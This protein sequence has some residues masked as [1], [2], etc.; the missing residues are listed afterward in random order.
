MSQ[1]SAEELEQLSNL[2]LSNDDQNTHL[3]FEIMEGKTWSATLLTELFVVCKLSGNDAFKQRAKAELERLDPNMSKVLA[4]KQKLSREGK[5]SSGANEKTIA[6]NIHYYVTVSKNQLDGIKLA[7]ALVQ[8]YGHG[9]QYLLDTLKGDA[10]IQYLSTFLQGNR[11]DFSK[12][13]VTKLPKEIFNIPGIEAVEE[14]DASGNK[15]ATLPS[16]IGQLSQLKKLNLSSNNLKKVH[17]NIQKCTQLEW[18][19]LSR[20][21]FKH[22]P[23]EICGCATLQE[24]HLLYCASYFSKEFMLS[25][26]LPNMAQ[27]HTLIFYRDNKDHAPNLYTVLAKCQQLKHLSLSEYTENPNQIAQLNKQLP[28]CTI[29]T[30]KT[31]SQLNY[32]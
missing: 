18:L 2:L 19:D 30:S 11:F 16:Q 29:S 31:L 13:G 22:F 3:A 27:L 1:L 6:K 20:N 23:E 9:Y 26:E 25:E 4:L 8:K 14:F 28:N 32:N 17:K 10:L 12:K 21:N 15:I 7:K 24:L 5:N